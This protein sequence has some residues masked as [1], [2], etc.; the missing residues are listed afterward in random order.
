[1]DEN[2]SIG[3][4]DTVG[5]GFLEPFLPK[6]RSVG[7][8]PTDFVEGQLSVHFEPGHV[9]AGRFEIIEQLGFGGMGAVYKVKD[10]LMPGEAKALKVMLP[11]LVHVESLRQ[12]FVAEVQAAQRLSHPNI[13]RV[14][15]IGEDQEQ[16]F[17]TMEFV[18]GKTLRGWLNERGG[19]LPMGEALQIVDQ[20]CAGLEE[21][22]RSTIHRDLKPQNIMILPGGT[23]KILDFGLAKL[24]TPGRMTRSS[25]ALGTAYYQAPEQAMDSANVDTRADIYSLG[26]IVY[27]ML[28]GKI[29]MAR[30]RAASQLNPDVPE[31]LDVV[32]DKM[33]QME[34]DDRPPSVAEVRRLLRECTR[35]DGADATI[36][37]QPRVREPSTPPASMDDAVSARIE[38]RKRR[39]N[40]ESADAAQYAKASYSKALEEFE[41][42]EEYDRLQAF[43]RAATAYQASGEFFARAAEEAP[44][45]EKIS[46]L[47][48]VLKKVAKKREVEE[49][50]ARKTGNAALEQDMVFIHGGTF[51]MGSR[52]GFLGIGVE[53]SSDERPMHEVTVGDFHLSKHAVTFQQY[54]AFCKA[55]GRKE[56]SDAGR[57]RGRRPV[58]CVS[59]NDALAYCK[60]LSEQTGKRYRLPTEAE[61]EYACRAGTRTRY[62]FGDNGRSL[63]EYA[64]Y[65]SNSGGKTH[66]VGS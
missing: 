35:A 6:G 22:H 61:W 58:I 1:V 9:I 40:A 5:D 14:H 30:A 33:L 50:Q 34:P 60:W 41:K 63:G 3:D 31:A 32:I 4:Q 28:T 15:D 51:M 21:A 18:E 19:R 20:I 44:V 54:D 10:R 11:V 36:S 47:A 37:L 27:E 65:S 46:V 56:P 52:R 2:K 12:R 8:L 55:T 29:P 62:N 17:F 57:G 13:V 45:G 7:D 66:E 53:G 24:M 38:A 23:V 49:K 25:M 42:G 59:W 26:I 16:Q 48:W 64:W 39:K 43:D